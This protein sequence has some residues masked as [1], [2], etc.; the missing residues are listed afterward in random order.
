MWQLSLGVCV[1]LDLGGCGLLVEFFVL[2]VIHGKEREVDVGGECQPNSG[3]P[4]Y[5]G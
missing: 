4:R 2:K 1:T 5:Y 3:G